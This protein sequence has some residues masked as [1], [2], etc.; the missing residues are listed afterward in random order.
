MIEPRL[1]SVIAPCRNERAD[2]AAFCAA[3]ARQSLPQGVAIEVLI[4]D[5]MSDDGTREVL[6]E[7]CARDNRFHLLDNPGRIVSCGLNRCLQHARGE[8]IVRMDLHTDYAVDYIARC[9][10]ALRN[11][12]ADNVGGPW[13]AVADPMQ[14][15]QQA[16]AAAF[17][18][19]WMAGGA[20]S[21]QLD[22]SGLVDTVYLGCWPRQVFE[23]F[24]GFDE[25]L[26]RNQDDEH[27]LRI[28]LGGGRVWQSRDIVSSYRPRRT[29]GAL[30][31]QYLQYGYWKPF[32]MRKHGR[33]ASMRQLLPG[34]ML[35]AS[36]TASMGALAGAP[37]WPLGLLAGLY[38]GAVLL[39]ATLIAAD[40]TWRVWWRLPCVI[41]AYHAS[42]GLGSL[43]GWFDVIRGATTGR[44]AF[45]RITR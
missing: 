36:I 37:L 2:V 30:F 9:V 38:A 22:Y 6:R 1:V 27:N 23:R 3:V 17:Q 4:A 12:Q 13:R 41:V 44:R 28:T 43:L 5:G 29:I 18:S 19:R 32:V 16:I 11:S 15:T 34:L 25:T 21:R 33:P 40:R 45:A 24:G 14:P 39:A 31:R 7:L 35:I 26:V 10:D 8:I 42:Y 20:R